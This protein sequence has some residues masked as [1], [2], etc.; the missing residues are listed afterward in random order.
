MRPA[1]LI[2]GLLTETVGLAVDILAERTAHARRAGHLGAEHH[3]IL[4]RDPCRAA[5]TSPGWR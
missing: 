4:R 5:S 2:A 1:A 3:G